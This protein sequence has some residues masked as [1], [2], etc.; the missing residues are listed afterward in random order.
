VPEQ[1]TAVLAS[2]DSAPARPAANLADLIRQQ[3]PLSEPEIL[4]VFSSVLKDL[5]FA[6]GQGML[7]KDITTARVI[8]SGAGWKLDEY[9]LA[10]VGAVRYMSPERCQ[11]KPL[12]ARSDIY[13]LG[14]VLYESATGRL[15][16]ADGLNYQIID[17]QVHKPP[18]PPRSVRPDI[19]AELE[20]VILRALT[21]S[22]TGRFQNAAEF[23]QAIEAI[24]PIADRPSAVRDQVS[25]RPVSRPVRRKQ[26]GLFVAVAAV[27]IAVA[28]LGVAK[29]GLLNTGS[30]TPAFVGLSREQAR[31]L[32]DKRQVALL[33]EEV[34]DARPEGTVVS[35]TP[36][37]GSRMGEKVRLQ[38]STGLATVPI[39]AG[40]TLEEASER[41]RSAGLRVAR[42]DSQYS[43]RYSADQIVAVGPKS[44]SRIRPEAAVTLT[45]A[46]GRATCPECGTRREPGAQFCI[47]CG[48]KY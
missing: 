21:K 10:R 42:V 15:P 40:F 35:Q 44:G 23:R 37:P 7:H 19:S 39:V 18:P 47:R 46:A 13:S 1:D 33:L 25:V 11:G 16:F 34:D 28:G 2:S 3:G 12:D 14:V 48:Y 32:A 29:L 41:L 6:H 38:V 22:P 26:T 5:E 17:A 27:V 8:R 4:S 24:R 9:G 20:R 30:A 36:A 43:D 31:S 45:V